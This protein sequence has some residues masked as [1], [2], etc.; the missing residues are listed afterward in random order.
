[1]V[2]LLGAGHNTVAEDG[3]EIYK[4]PEPE[5]LSA[6]QTLR[7]TAIQGDM[8]VLADTINTINISEI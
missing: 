6:I 4:I 7:Q 8:D 1:V 5:K 2:Q 3:M